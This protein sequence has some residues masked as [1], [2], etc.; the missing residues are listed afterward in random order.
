MTE[1]FWYSLWHSLPFILIIF[2]S[3]VGVGVLVYS[4]IV[5]YLNRKPVI[6]H[7]ID[8]VPK[9]EDLYGLSG[10][11]SQIVFAH[12]EKAYSYHHLHTVQVEVTNQSK[13]D[14][15]EF[16][17]GIKLPSDAGVVYIEAQSPDRHRVVK[18]LTSFG[19]DQPQ[20][21]IDLSLQPFNREDA[22]TFRLLIVVPEDSSSL[23]AITLSSPEAVR[24]VD[25]PTTQEMLKAAAKSISLPI[26][27]FKISFR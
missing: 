17:F 7:R 21:Q 16:E 20:S 3:G 26:G 19:F 1:S 6:A 9:F 18:S 12:A 24:F 10:L 23:D 5:A 2:G 11:Q 22:Y 14:F 13:Y 25:L 27:P 8:V 4:A 15:D